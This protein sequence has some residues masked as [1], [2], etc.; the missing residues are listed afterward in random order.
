MMS[1]KLAAT[2]T[3]DS[4]LQDIAAELTSAAYPLV[5]RHGMQGSWLDLELGLWRTLTDT[6]EHGARQTPPGS[7]DELD[8]W[9]E[10]FLVE[11]TGEASHV[12]RRHGVK[13][14]LQGMAW[15]LHRAFR[16]VIET[17]RGRWNIATPGEPD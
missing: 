1:D 4:L 7:P 2:S 14:S 13:R 5:L 8:L 12:V 6:V 11:L 3:R 9:R 15:D 17:D 10:R 16:S